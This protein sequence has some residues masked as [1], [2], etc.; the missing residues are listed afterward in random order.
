MTR[1]INATTM[2]RAALIREVRRPR[3]IERLARAVHDLGATPWASD[4]RALLLEL[5]GVEAVD[6]PHGRCDACG[7]ERKSAG[8]CAESWCPVAKRGAK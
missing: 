6:G 1:P 4:K 8:V 3:R 2:S 7:T 5:W